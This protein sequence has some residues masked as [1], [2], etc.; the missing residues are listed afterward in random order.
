MK[1]PGLVFL[2]TIKHCKGTPQG[3]AHCEGAPLSHCTCCHRRRAPRHSCHACQGTRALQTEALAA[4][5]L[6]ASAPRTASMAHCSLALLPSSSP[7][8]QMHLLELLS[9]R[10]AA[11]QCHSCCSAGVSD[12][13][14]LLLARLVRFEHFWMASGVQILH[15]HQYYRLQMKQR[16][17]ADAVSCHVLGTGCMSTWG[18]CWL[19][20]PVDSGTVPES[21]RFRS[22]CTSGPSLP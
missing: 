10:E 16:I 12:P 11:H 1:E 20:G 19:S 5:S 21:L 15:L 6:L 22:L 18:R 14:S 13:P 3:P 8:S 17:S 4:S 9:Y 7:G 2:P